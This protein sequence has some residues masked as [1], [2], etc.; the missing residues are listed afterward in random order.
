MK[1]ST[2]VVCFE[3][4]SHGGKSISRTKSCTT[5]NSCNGRFAL[6][7]GRA[8]TVAQHGPHLEHECIR[9]VRRLYPNRMPI[10]HFG[11]ERKS[12]SGIDALRRIQ[13]CVRWKWCLIHGLYALSVGKAKCILLF[14]CQRCNAKAHQTAQHQNCSA[15]YG[16]AGHRFL[17]FCL[18]NVLLCSERTHRGRKKRVE[19]MLRYKTTEENRHGCG[20]VPTVADTHLQCK[21]LL[22]GRLDL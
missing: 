16:C 19:S 8:E 12:P 22:V 10:A 4:V 1:S 17:V 2:N 5:L 14:S 15:C 21:R 18:A 11:M 3:V 9:I 13:L 20:R 6:S 7:S